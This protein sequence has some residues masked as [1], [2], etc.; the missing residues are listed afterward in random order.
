MVWGVAKP[1]SSGYNSVIMRRIRLVIILLLAGLALTGYFALR[2]LGFLGTTQAA[3][4]VPKG[5]QEI[6]WI[7]P[8]T[9]GANWER[10]VAGIRQVA[11]ERPELIVLDQNA[12]PDQTAVVPE[13][14]LQ[15]PGCEG[16]LWFRWY[17]MTS[18]LG[19]DKWVSELAR[20]DPAPL[21]IIGGGTSD[22]ARDLA[23]A[24]AE[25]QP[26]IPSARCCCSPPPPPTR[27]TWNGR[28]RI[29]P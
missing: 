19:T 26:G 6:A 13:I 23:E 3:R 15:L 9:S 25:R 17:K 10:F 2:S 21:A 24:M 8:A 20:R 7:N 4:P 5:D 29:G 1:A 27:S 22:R 14:G 16:R 12:F 28:I 11:R 18:D